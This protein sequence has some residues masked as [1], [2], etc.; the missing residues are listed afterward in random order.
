MRK[1]DHLGK[2]FTLFTVGL[3]I[4]SLGISLMIVA[5]FGA[6][7]WDVLH[8][9][10]YYQFGLTIGTWSIIAGFVILGTAGLIMKEWPQ[11]GAYLNMVLVGIFIDM[12]MMIPM[13]TEPGSWAGKLLMFMV[14]MIIYAYGMGIYLAAQLGSGPRDSFMLAITAKTN[15][16][17]SNARRAM[18]I[19]V[20]II[21]WSLGGPV[22]AGTIIFSILAGTFIGYALPQCQSLA[23]S[24][25]QKPSRKQ[26]MKEIERGVS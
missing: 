15:W 12:I 22:F 18:E 23:D 19:G 2:R 10:L 4:M 16:K 3:F 25:L 13:L 7:P 14:G 20:L 9:G 17:I 24:W 1:R 21:G 26:V 5:D 11:F 8:V 6:A